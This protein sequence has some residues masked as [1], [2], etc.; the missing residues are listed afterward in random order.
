MTVKVGDWVVSLVDEKD[1]VKGNEYKVDRVIG[2][3]SISVIDDAGDEHCLLKGEYETVAKPE[4][5]TNYNDGKWHLWSGED[6]LPKS[7]HG[8]STIQYVWYDENTGEVGKSE[9]QADWDESASRPAWDQV[10]KFRVIKEHRE[11]REWHVAVNSKGQVMGC[12]EWHPTSSLA[13]ELGTYTLVKVRE[14]IE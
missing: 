12:K 5:S 10:L 2:S 1:L 13:E 7:V 9:G 3:T 11:P 4:T 14:V 8:K 6:V